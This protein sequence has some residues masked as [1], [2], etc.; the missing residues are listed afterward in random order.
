[1]SMKLEVVEKKTL[2]CQY[3]GTKYARK[4][5]L[6]K[7]RRQGYRFESQTY[8]S[9]LEVKKKVD[10]FLWVRKLVDTQSYDKVVEGCE[11]VIPKVPCDFEVIWEGHIMM[12]E[13]K[14][15][16]LEYF[17]MSNIKPHQLEASK[18]CE[19]AGG[20][21]WFLI[22]PLN[23]KKKRIFC[24][25]GKQMRLLYKKQRKVKKLT[26]TELTKIA[27]KKGKILIAEKQGLFDVEE[28]VLDMEIWKC[29]KKT[30]VG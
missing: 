9:F 28:L 13:C 18:D 24:I 17:N 7:I 15:T 20:D 19:K 29:G 16:T 5:H 6:A 1:M 4:K 8:K 23:D 22:R 11:V 12:I 26:F 30:K 10:G 2:K 3:R 14:T 25:R 21:Y 27:N